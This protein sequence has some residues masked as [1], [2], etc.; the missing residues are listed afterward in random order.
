M[1]IFVF[2]YK[3]VYNLCV[4]VYPHVEDNWCI[5]YTRLKPSHLVI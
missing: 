4:I 5:G 2:L 3:S 1:A